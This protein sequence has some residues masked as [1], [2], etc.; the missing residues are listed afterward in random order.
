MLGLR[1]HITAAHRVRAN[2]EVAPASRKVRWSEEELIMLAKTEAKL[3]HEGK[4]AVELNGH[5]VTRFNGTRSLES[6]KGQRRK[7][8][9]KAA[10]ERELAVLRSRP[11]AQ[12]QV[13]TQDDEAE[14]IDWTAIHLREV[15]QLRSPAA[16]QMEEMLTLYQLYGVVSDERLLAWLKR[17]TKASPRRNVQNPNY[18]NRV[19]GSARARRR[20]AYARM[21]NLWRKNQCQAAREILDPK[22][23][24]YA[25]PSAEAMFSTW[26][27]ILQEPSIEVDMSDHLLSTSLARIWD[28]VSEEELKNNELDRSSAPGLDGITVSAWRRVHPKLRVAF[29]HIVM[30]NGGFPPELE[31]GRTIF[32][33]KKPGSL[34][35][36]DQR[37][38]TVTSVVVRHFNKVLARRLTL[39]HDWDP[40]QRAFLPADGCAENLVALQSVINDAKTNLNEVHVGSF[41]IAKAYD[42][43][44]HDAVVCI[45]RKHGAPEEFATYLARGYSNLKTVLQYE[46]QEREVSVNRGVRQGDPLSPPLFNLVI[47]MALNKLDRDIGYRI[48]EESVIN[49]IC[50][51]D[52]TILISSTVQ[53]LQRNLDAFATE[54]AGFGLKMN[55]SKCAVLS[56]KPDGKRKKFKVL[57]ESQFELD[58]QALPQIGVLGVWK[59]LGVNFIGSQIGGGKDDF[60]RKLELITRAPLKPQQRLIVLRRY[61][62]PQYTHGWVLGRMELCA[63]KKID[64]V[65]RAVVRQ[66]LKLPKDLTTAAFHAPIQEGGLGIPSM[67]TLIPSLKQARFARLANSSSPIMRSI[68]NLRWMSHMLGKVHSCVAKFVPDGDGKKEKRYWTNRLHDSVDGKDLVDANKTPVS[69]YWVERDSHIISGRD[70]I[71]LTRT[72]YNCLPSKVRTSRGRNAD[73]RCRAGCG[74]NETTYHIV[75][76]CGRTHAGRVKRHDKVVDVMATELEATGWSVHKEPQF[77]TSVGNRKPDL[78]LVDSTKIIVLDAHVVTASNMRLA[79][80]EK[81]RKYASISGFD[82]LVVNRFGGGRTVEHIPITITYK[83]IWYWRSLQ[84]LQ[85]LGVT[86]GALARVSRYVLFG[87]YMNFRRF[88]ETTTRASQATS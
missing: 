28:H 31:L 64:R 45:A 85:Q 23:A 32:I 68:C 58:G 10:V 65:I 4:T 36:K 51:A 78:V 42:S 2:E 77:R 56:I 35:P 44:S 13:L 21:Q 48:D 87:S 22:P 63:Y 86:L 61:L 39:S 26:T 24:N 50:Y 67:A 40:R 41:D 73:T 37:P 3:V 17:V 7:P 33:A 55:P 76:K 83:G 57:T 82:S 47:E 52:D 75:Q 6:I 70:Y 84:K 74:S 1:R 72:R 62:L 34:D 18:A 9:H 49:G 30:G 15:E 16:R 5:L 53:G 12:P 60:T 38:I 27:E 54:L 71:S 25:S 43:V 11:L 88:M 81:E 66:W 8:A 29:Y 79:H 20:G 59:Y 46:G 14:I 19:Q 69:T 80:H